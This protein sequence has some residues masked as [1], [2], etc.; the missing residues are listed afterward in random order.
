MDPVTLLVSIMMKN[1]D[2][3]AG[4]ARMT[5][6]VMAPGTVNVAAMQASEADLSQGILNCY[7]P[8]AR[9]HHTDIV[10][11]PFLLRLQVSQ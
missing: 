3:L 7:H 1:P 2:A 8:S 4:A 5:K 6:S 10:Q 11:T 9:F